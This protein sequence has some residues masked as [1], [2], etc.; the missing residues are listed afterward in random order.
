MKIARKAVGLKDEVKGI[1][2]VPNESLQDKYL[3]RLK[4]KINIWA[5]LL[6][7]VSPRMVLSNI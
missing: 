2:N 5:C 3:G 1:L 7:L 4:K 6:M